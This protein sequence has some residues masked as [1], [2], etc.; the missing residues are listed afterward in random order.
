MLAAYGS[1]NI[2][3]GESRRESLAGGCGGW[4]GQTQHW[5]PG[6]REPPRSILIMWVNQEEL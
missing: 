1:E 2:L 3:D 6:R 4:L 5:F